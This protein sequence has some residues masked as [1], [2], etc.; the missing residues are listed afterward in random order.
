MVELVGV[1]MGRGG[2][3]AGRFSAG[4]VTA[5]TGLSAARRKGEDGGEFDAEPG[6][7]HGVPEEVRHGRHAGRGYAD[8][9]FYERGEE[10]GHRF[11]SDVEGVGVEFVFEVNAK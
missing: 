1:W 4:W 6:E 2:R 11:V 9:H 3:W 7:G 10:D 5:G 8:A